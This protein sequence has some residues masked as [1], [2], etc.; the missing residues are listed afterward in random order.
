MSPR[1]TLLL[2]CEECERYPILISALQSAEFDL[3]TT[4]KPETAMLLLG[5]STV[6]A[7]LIHPGKNLARPAFVALKRRAPRAPILLFDVDDQSTEKGQGLY[8]VVHVNVQDDV[9]VHAVAIFLRESLM[10]SQSPRAAE[11]AGRTAA[12][13]PPDYIVDG[14]AGHH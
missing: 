14:H 6:D 12:K 3:I 7:M 2:I 13:S 5:Q 1:L 4:D 10:L 8:S 11:M 9:L